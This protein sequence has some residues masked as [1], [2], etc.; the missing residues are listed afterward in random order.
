MGFIETLKYLR[1]GQGITQ[2]E[3]AKGCNLSPQCISALEIGRNLPNSITLTVIAKY[4]NVSVD[5]LLGLE[6]DYGVKVTAPIG[7]MYS[8]EER[9]LIED[10]RK[11]TRLK[12]DLIKGNIK[13]MLPTDAESEKKK[14]NI[15]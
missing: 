4:F 2:K 13:A 14:K 8:T 15:D 9:Q 6:N 1:E 11:L 10:F 7:E 12:Q 5:Y 3:L